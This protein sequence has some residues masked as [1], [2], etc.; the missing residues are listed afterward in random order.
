MFILVISVNNSAFNDL[1]KH[2]IFITAYYKFESI[3]FS[4]RCKRTQT[5]KTLIRLFIWS[6]LIIVY[7]VCTVIVVLTLRIST[8]MYYIFYQPQI[9]LY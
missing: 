9:G 6:S 4:F 1:L 2:A 8:V 7:T 3:H 5:L